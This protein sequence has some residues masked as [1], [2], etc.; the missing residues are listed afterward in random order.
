MI[1]ENN[2]ER[3]NDNVNVNNNDDRINN[4]NLFRDIAANNEFINLIRRIFDYMFDNN[5]D[6][7]CMVCQNPGDKL[8]LEKNIVL[9]ILTTD[10]YDRFRA[11]NIDDQVSLINKAIYDIVGEN[12]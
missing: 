4:A 2:L 8:N 9:K 6:N 5:I 10:N 11:L 1:I 3:R 7:V 12:Q